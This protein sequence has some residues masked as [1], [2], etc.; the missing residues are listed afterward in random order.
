MNIVKTRLTRD[1]GLVAHVGLWSS[2]SGSGNLGNGLSKV[3]SGRRGHWRREKLSILA[4]H[5]F[6]VVEVGLRR[7]GWWWWLMNKMQLAF[8]AS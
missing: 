8:C 6:G 5:A 7:R 1:N 3:R 4:R 2:A